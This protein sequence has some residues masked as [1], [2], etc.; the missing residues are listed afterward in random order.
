[1]AVI[2]LDLGRYEAARDRLLAL[3]KQ[4]AGAD[5]RATQFRL[6][7]TA[8]VE[9]DDAGRALDWV[10]AAKAAIPAATGSV[11]W[12]YTQQVEARALDLA[13][14]H[15]EALAEM[16]V[17]IARLLADGN[18]AD[19]YL[20]LRAQRYRAQFLVNAGRDAE[21]LQ[22]MRDLRE[23]HA[24]GKAPPFELGLLLDALGEAELRAGNGEKSQIA[25]EEAAHLLAKQLPKD[26]PYVIRNAA[27][28]AT[29]RQAT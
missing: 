2:D 18:A 4:P 8:Y 13:G 17:V 3:V 16:D 9:L 21:G 5:G 7:A 24:S 25:H 6:L 20:L 19:S 27:L 12:P 15:E 22:A 23:R 1:M 29:A 14:R 11:E 26:H 10:A 28:R